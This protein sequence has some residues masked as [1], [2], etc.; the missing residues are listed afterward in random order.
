M[1]I[2]GIGDPMSGHNS[3]AAIVCDGKLIA[4]A[5]EE[6][7][8]RV[9]H[10]GGAPVRAIGFCL[11]RAG[12]TM[13]EVD[14]IACA[15]RPF[16]IGKNSEFI[17]VDGHLVRRLT[18][19]RHLRW[20]AGV[21]KTM[22]DAARRMHLPLD[23]DLGMYPRVR[24]T[25]DTIREWYGELPPVRYFQHHRSH[26][27]A[28][29]FTSGHERAAIATIDARGGLYSTVTWRGEGNRL[30]LMRAEPFSNS[31]GEFY[32]RATKH[33]G[34]GEFGEG[35][36]MGLAPYG[37]KHRF[38]A[39]I[40]E[41]L[42][43]AGPEWYVH[44]RERSLRDVVGPPR[45]KGEDIMSGDF[46]DIAAAAQHALE[47]AVLRIV[48]SAL[49][50][51]NARHLCLGGG[52]N[53]NCSSNGVLRAGGVADSIS[54]FP[55]PADNG[56]AVGAALLCAS[57]SGGVVQEPL[58]DAYLGPEFSN[59][60]CSAAIDAEP[61]VVARQS[62]DVAADGARM[63]AAGNIIGWFQGRLEIGPRALGNRSIVADPRTIETRDRVNEV[64]R[65]EKWRPL[66]PSVLSERAPEFF[67]LSGES[68]F[69]LFAAQVRAEARARA[70][71]IVHVDGSARPQTV[72][73]DR[74]P[75]FHALIEAFSQHSGLPI[76]LNTSFNDAGE[77]I[78]CTPA[79][80]LRTFLTTG[81]DALLMNDFIV[82]RCATS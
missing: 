38:A 40:S 32:D 1:N 26:A 3:S 37:D 25:F 7:F 53:L 18:S 70:A 10:D 6:R 11:Q 30:T 16:R 15:S 81:L 8:S 49:E 14:V 80:A 50:E 47:E 12:L 82:E 41:V 79:D 45:A 28:A 71:A 52:V 24:Q 61:R 5:E 17:D 46:A 78:V 36:L 35:K 9:K 66:A 51:A 4:A 77:P 58:L 65:R 54:V 76:V 48:R 27:A 33:A 62:A 57:E 42:N 39:Q 56:L 60:D 64:K 68:P 23:F 63:I 19:T 72:R 73:R 55:A 22:L 59:A 69:M 44:H 75:R 2:L 43:T 67:E 31:L 34:L 29:F 74:N 21:Y 20:E 13:R